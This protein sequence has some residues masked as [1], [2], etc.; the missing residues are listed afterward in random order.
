MVDV[1]LFPI[2]FIFRISSEPKE[3]DPIL[4]W[5]PKHSLSLTVF[6]EAQK[7]VWGCL[8]KLAN[9]VGQKGPKNELIHLKRFLIGHSNFDN[10]D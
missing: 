6:V 4:I 9:I 1:C 5:L 10:F 8:A 2:Q 7:A 3:I